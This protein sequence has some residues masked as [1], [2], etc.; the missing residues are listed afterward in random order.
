MRR[1]NGQRGSGALQPDPETRQ[2][3]VANGERFV[4][5]AQRGADDR[6][7]GLNVR[8]VVQPGPECDDEPRSRMS[9]RRSSRQRWAHRCP[10][11]SQRRGNLMLS[12]QPIGTI[13]VSSDLGDD[14]VGPEPDDRVVRFLNQYRLIDDETQLLGDLDRCTA[15]RRHIAS[16]PALV[17]TAAG[18]CMILELQGA[19]FEGVVQGGPPFEK[20]RLNGAMLRGEQLEGANFVLTQLQ[21]AYFTGAQLEGPEGPLRG[22]GSLGGHEIDPGPARFSDVQQ[23]DE[24][25]ARAENQVAGD[26]GVKDA[27]C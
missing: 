21:G 27:D 23:T 3:Q 2:R 15:V 11:C 17:G 24:A 22:S 12:N 25:T 6:S 18:R 13:R 20:A 26:S 16:L 9:Q 7:R 19:M 14:R 8:I 5:L 1:T 4:N 10:K